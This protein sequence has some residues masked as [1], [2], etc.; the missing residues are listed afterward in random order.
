MISKDGPLARNRDFVILWVGGAVSELGTSMSQLVFPLVGYAIT[1]STVQAGLATTGLALGEVVLRLPAG[2]LVDRI[3]RNR[4]L[5]LTNLAAAAVYGSLAIAVLTGRLTVVHLVI[6][7]FL[8]GAADAFAAPATSATIRTIVPAKQLALAYTRL[9]ARS[10]AVR[11]IGPP[12]GGALYSLARGVPFVVDA[13]SYTAEAFAVTRLRT[14]LPAPARERR[15]VRA[16]IGEGLRFVWEHVGVRAMMIWGGLI[17]LAGGFVFV[18]I[19][20]RL[21]Q[22]GTRPAVIGLVETAAAAAG[23]AGAL[24]APMIIARAPTG[25]LTV[26]LPLARRAWWC[27][28][29]GR[30]MPS[31]QAHCSP[32]ARS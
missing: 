21:I 28:S 22:A 6:A 16:D 30:R 14:P 18:A 9:E 5:L 3:A 1:H 12:A 2:A 10:R 31:R 23:L 13:V 7:G 27:R 19:T 15:S 24:A 25:L 8:S 17:N 26:V 32:P 4:V 20:L 11:L 29:R